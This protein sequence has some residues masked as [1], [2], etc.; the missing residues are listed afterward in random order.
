MQTYILVTGE[1]SEKEDEN[2]PGV[3]FFEIDSELSDE[4]Q[5]EATLNCFHEEFGIEC[6]DDFSITVF[7]ENFKEICENEHNN[8]LGNHAEC[9]G[10]SDFDAEDVPEEI[11]TYLSN[12]YK[13]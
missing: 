11:K 6:L 8:G 10:Y 12:K 5:A 1:A 2:I 7:N 4:E 3:Y 9:L 13:L